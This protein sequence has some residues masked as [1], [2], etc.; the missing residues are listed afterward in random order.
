MFMH[1]ALWGKSSG[2][3]IAAHQAVEVRRMDIDTSKW[4]EWTSTH[5]LARILFYHRHFSAFKGIKNDFLWHSF[6]C[7][8]K[9]TITLSAVHN[10]IWQDYCS[11]SIQQLG[12]KRKA[13]AFVNMVGPL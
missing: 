1:H 12:Q 4:D 11:V 6:G 10:Y 7:Y 13:R 2:L 8:S 9:H 5:R 3:V